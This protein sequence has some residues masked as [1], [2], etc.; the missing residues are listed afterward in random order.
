[1]GYRGDSTIG[2][3]NITQLIRK[4]LSRV[5]VMEF[6]S[7]K[8]ESGNYYLKKSVIF[9]PIFFC[10]DNFCRISAKLFVCHCIA[11]QDTESTATP[12]G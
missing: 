4:S 11:H 1:M 12:S 9:E 7:E 8:L 2:H 10:R 6:D 3:E 5:T